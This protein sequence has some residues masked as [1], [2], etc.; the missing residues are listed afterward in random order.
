MNLPTVIQKVY[1]F[2]SGIARPRSLE[3]G[4]LEEAG[5]NT[6]DTNKVIGNKELGKLRPG[7][8]HGFENIKLQ[9][10][11]Q[12]LFFITPFPG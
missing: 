2:P 5:R 9:V 11:R 7:S 3:V 6:A 8:G 1:V 4:K 12:H 10:H